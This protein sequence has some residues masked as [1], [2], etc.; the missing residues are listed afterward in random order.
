[1]AKAY[2]VLS[3]ESWNMH[4]LKRSSGGK[5]NLSP[6]ASIVGDDIR[7]KPEQ[8]ASRREWSFMN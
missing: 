6:G 2:A 1:M 4:Q 3:R 5:L 8:E 7:L